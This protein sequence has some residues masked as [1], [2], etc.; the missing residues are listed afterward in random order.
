MLGILATLSVIIYGLLAIAMDPMDDLR[1]STSPDKPALI[2]ARVKLLSLDKPWYE[3][4]WQWLTNLVQGDP[5][6][7]WRTQQPVAEILPGAVWTSIQLIFAATVFSILLGVTIGVIS[8]LRQYT[9]FD[10]T[11]T[12]VSFV[13]YSLPSFWVAVLLKQ[14]LAIELNN[15]INDPQLSVIGVLVTSLIAALF[16]AGIL[17]GAMK[18]R[19][20][21]FTTAFVVTL[22]TLVY[23]VKS[24]WI[25]NPSIGFLGIGI[26]GAAAA[27]VFTM[28]LAGLKNKRALG[29]S[30]TTAAVGLISYFAM[31]WLFATYEMTYGFIFWLL[32]IAIVISVA[33][34]WLWGGPDKS[35]SMRISALTGLVISVLIYFDAVMSVWVPYNKSTAINNRPIATIGSV[36]PN[37]GGDFWITQ[38]DRFTHLLLPSV[39]LVLISF[40]TYVR[41]ER[42]ATL[43]VLNQDYIR[44]AR[45]KGLPERVVIVRHA[46]RN[47]LMPLASI[48]PVDIVSLIGGAVITETIFGWA[49]MYAL[50]D[51]RIQVNA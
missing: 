28:I 41:Y 51:P 35:L 20:I 49:G 23:I 26:T 12:F 3:R 11:I 32:V 1:M 21:V 15:F 8:A 5:G 29:A 37:L 46:L 38:L 42:G 19:A 44:T 9:A 48:I 39:V 34:G 27:V 17:G 25:N 43:E 13:L 24:G 22:G 40:A 4:Y 14:Y 7:A 47:A 2:E 50:L 45:A 36:T 18:R 10:Y 16:W 31:T 6:T 33:I 30:L